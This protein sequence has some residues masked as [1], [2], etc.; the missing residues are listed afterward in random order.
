MAE[1][2]AVK[3]P[4][5]MASADCRTLSNCGYSGTVAVQAA[6]GTDSELAAPML[7]R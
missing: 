2:I 7:S 1:V 3:K 4:A 6:N 5:R